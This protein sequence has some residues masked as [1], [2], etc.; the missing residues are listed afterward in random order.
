MA[1]ETAEERGKPKLLGSV[2][3]LAEIL[4]S[5]VLAIAVMFLFLFRFAGVVGT[6]MTPTLQH[7]DWLAVGAF[8]RSP[9]RGDIIIIAQPNDHNEPLVKRVIA[10]GGQV[11][12][13]AEGRV[14]VDGAVIEE[15]YLP[16]GVVTSKAPPSQAS[17]EFPVTV[18]EGFVFVMGDNRGGSS[19]SRYKEVGFIQEDYILGKVHLRLVPFGQF[20][21]K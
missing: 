5:A 18:P 3:E 10:T 1:N 2:Y 9:K 14:L 7:K 16:S 4:V 19:D 11:V 20:I 12:D 8:A 21:V 17:V 15:P 13:I 6:S